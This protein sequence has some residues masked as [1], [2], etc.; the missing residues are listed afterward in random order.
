MDRSPWY[1][2]SKTCMFIRNV[3]EPFDDA[4]CMFFHTF[5]HFHTLSLLQIKLSCIYILLYIYIYIYL[6]VCVC[7]CVVNLIFV[8]TA[9]SR[10]S[11]NFVVNETQFIY[12]ISSSKS[13]TWIKHRSFGC[14]HWNKCLSL[15]SASSL[16]SAAL[17]NVALI[18]IVTIF[19]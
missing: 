1:Q 17:L 2:T 13:W 18:R 9:L 3:F 8:C 11:T 12:H 14:P 15:I 16:I 6:S 4:F 7:V 5:T 10:S 19:Y